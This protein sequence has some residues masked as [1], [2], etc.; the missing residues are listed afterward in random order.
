MKAIIITDIEQ[1]MLKSLDNAQLEALHTVLEQVLKDVTI[2]ASAENTEKM[3]N[4]DI[5]LR[6]SCTEPRDLAIIDMLAST[7]MRVGEMVG[8]NR[9]DI[10]FI[11][12][13]CVVLGKGDKERA[14][15]GEQYDL[16]YGAVANDNV[17]QTI[18]LYM[19]GVLT[20]EQALEAL[21]NVL[22][23]VLENVTVISSAETEEKADNSAL[24]MSLD[25]YGHF[26]VDMQKTSAKKCPVSFRKYFRN[27]I[28]H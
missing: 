23:S 8:L 3:T 9:D 2:T 12:R 13:E 19:S 18:T 14:Y 10:N 26:T 5:L 20:K 28:G 1:A 17:Y 24:V 21:H 4:T 7:G 22:N 25:V 11:E 6:D 15:S 16:I 27:E